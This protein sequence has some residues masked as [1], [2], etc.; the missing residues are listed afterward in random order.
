MSTSR[1][2]EAKLSSSLRSQNLDR[3]GAAETFQATST[4]IIQWY[5]AGIFADACKRLSCMYIETLNVSAL[6]L[7]ALFNVRSE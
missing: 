2:F 1:N 4:F 7:S 3:A 6:S 5:G